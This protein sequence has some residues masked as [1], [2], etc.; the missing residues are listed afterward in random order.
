MRLDAAVARIRRRNVWQSLDL[1]ILL[2]RRWYGPLLAL[3]LCG[4][5]F[6]APALAL[7]AWLLPEWGFVLAVC[8]ALPLLDAPLT[9]WAGRALF[10]ERPILRETLALFA[11]RLGPRLLWRLLR[12]RLHPHRPIAYA[13]LMLEDPGPDAAGPR[14]RQLV[15]GVGDGRAGGES[16]PLLCALV[17]LLLAAALLAAGV[18]LI[19]EEL[20]WFDATEFVTEGAGLRILF[21]AWLLVCALMAPFH[22]CGGFMLY[23]S[24]RVDLEA[25]DLELG[26]RELNRRL[27]AERR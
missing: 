21:A 10:A 20:R 13:V 9:L 26:L 24:R 19:P 27:R 2:A 5:A 16:V 11:R 23:I 25:W 22:F 17:N 14:I 1:G 18:A 7:A 8:L 3:W 12:Y 15:Q 4:A 6:L